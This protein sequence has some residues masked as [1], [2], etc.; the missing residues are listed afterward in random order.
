LPFRCCRYCQQ[1][2]Q[3]SKYRPDQSVCSL[4]DCQRQRRTDHHRQ[5]LKADSEYAEVVRDSQRKWRE[6]HPEYQKQYRQSHPAAA[7]QNRQQQRRRDRKRR[8][9]TLVKNNLA[10]DLKRSAAEVWLV[11]PAARDLEK[12]N[13]VSCQFLIFQS[14]AGNAEARPS[15]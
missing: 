11:G 13:L 2:F 8:V 7:E 1:S 12:N 14:V 6:A 15:S 4:A 5:K 3:P 9:E 10:F